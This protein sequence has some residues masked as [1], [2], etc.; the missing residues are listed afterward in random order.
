MDPDRLGAG[1]E[2]EFDEFLAEA[3]DLVLEAAPDPGR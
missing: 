1:V 3:D 2:A